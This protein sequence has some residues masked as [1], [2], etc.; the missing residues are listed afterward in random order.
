M[1][2][3]IAD[4][5]IPLMLDLAQFEQQMSQVEARIQAAG[6]AAQQAGAAAS[7]AAS[8]AQS[9]AGAAQSAAG[10]AASAAQSAS[11]GFASSSYAGIPGLP[12]N[13]ET[14]L[15][16]F[17]VGA[18]SL[19]QS[20]KQATDP[21]S[22]MGSGWSLREDIGAAVNFAS[23]YIPGTGV[24][25]EA[26]RVGGGI[27]GTGIM[28]GTEKA[29]QE[30]SGKLNE[31]IKKAV[32]EA[33]EAGKRA[34]EAESP[35]R[36][37]YR[38]IGS[39]IIQGVE[40]AI[41]GG[42][43]AIAGAMITSLGFAFNQWK[44][45]TFGGTHVGAG[46]NVVANPGG[47]LGGGLGGFLGAIGGSIQD[48]FAIA[49]P[50]SG[51]M[52]GRVFMS[53]IP[54][55]LRNMGQGLLDSVLGSILPG[56]IAGPIGQMLGTMFGLTPILQREAITEPGVMAG[57]GGFKDYPYGGGTIFNTTNYF[58]GGNF[59]DVE[60]QVQT[61]ILQSARRLGVSI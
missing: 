55:G 57:A 19:G 10:Q 27:L 30:G 29:V 53:N 6:Q 8:Q 21:R 52:A 39:P 54:M 59:T 26:A 36:R 1:A 56:F 7:Q 12:S 22:P 48:S 47:M 44:A 28:Q 34:A 3:H 49:Q 46:L 31:A 41:L 33:I 24:A 11:S 51:A 40:M 58:Q 9:A 13:T 16:R 4:A 43:T 32:D 38:E 25:A 42:S 23:N 37:S 61:G 17:S 50:T 60:R 2:V 35:S 18:S 14:I 45:A 20:I 15:D 5:V